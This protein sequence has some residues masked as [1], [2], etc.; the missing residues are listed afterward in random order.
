[1]S[2]ATVWASGHPGT[3]KGVQIGHFLPFG[4]L[5]TFQILNLKK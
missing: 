2:W 1:M 3:G 5:F 4:R